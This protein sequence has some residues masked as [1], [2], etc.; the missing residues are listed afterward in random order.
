M[1]TIWGGGTRLASRSYM[2]ANK[3]PQSVAREVRF[4]RLSGATDNVVTVV[5]R[6]QVPGSLHC[7]RQVPRLTTASDYS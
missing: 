4:G 7:A 3:R 6:L 1:E 2:W 5:E